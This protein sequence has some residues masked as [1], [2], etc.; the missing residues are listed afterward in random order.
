MEL[1]G[2]EILERNLVET[3]EVIWASSQDPRY[4]HSNILGG[5]PRTDGVTQNELASVA[6]RKQGWM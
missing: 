3:A 1:F 2:T 4:C 5:D 6:E